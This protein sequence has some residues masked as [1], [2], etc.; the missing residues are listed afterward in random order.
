MSSVPAGARAQPAATHR[1][2]F[3]L[4]PDPATRERL[5]HV[6]EALAANRPGLRRVHPARYHATV[7]FLGN[8]TA[9]RSGLVDAAV[10]AAGTVRGAPFAW[11]L[12]GVASFHGRQPPCVLRGTATPAGLQQLWHRLGQALLLNGLGGHL[13]RRFIPH[14]TLAYSEG[15]LLEPAPIAPIVWPVADFAL[16]HSVVGQGGYRTLGCWALARG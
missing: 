11:T 12:D 9:L 8:D 15:A 14:V 5:A 4:V 13:E 16:L 1:L 3:A 7:H 2:F 10:A 6:G